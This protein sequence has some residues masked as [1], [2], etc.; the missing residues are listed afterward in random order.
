VW[1]VGNID[2]LMQ[3]KLNEALNKQKDCFFNVERPVQLANSA[4]KSDFPFLAR[5]FSVTMQ[6]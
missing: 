1:I 6:V 4:Q 5:A 2:A 3:S